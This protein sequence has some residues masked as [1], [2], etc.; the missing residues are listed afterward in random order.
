MPSCREAI[1]RD[2]AENCLGHR[3]TVRTLHARPGETRQL[4]SHRNYIYY[5]YYIDI[6]SLDSFLTMDRID[7]DR[8][9]SGEVNLGVRS[10]LL[11]RRSFIHPDSPDIHHGRPIRPRRRRWCR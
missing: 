1:A 6:L 11:A 3:L 10:N 5:I 7:M 9:K 4:N 2:V 8:L